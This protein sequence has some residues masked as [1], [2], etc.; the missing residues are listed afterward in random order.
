MDTSSYKGGRTIENVNARAVLISGPPGIGKTSTVR[1]IAKLNNYKTF[2]L[3]ASDQRNK[4]IVNQKVGFL[5]NNFTLSSCE[6]S[7]SKNLI[8]DTTKYQIIKNKIL[9][10]LIKTYLSISY[11][12]SKKIFNN[13]KTMYLNKK[14]LES[15]VLN[16]YITKPYQFIEKTRKE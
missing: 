8:I 3:N 6:E 12:I 4:G 16:F 13:K 14:S 10:A 9:K 2:E 1:L 5:M 11:K 15:F 7:N